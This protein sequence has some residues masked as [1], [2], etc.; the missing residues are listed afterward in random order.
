MLNLKLV[1]KMSIKREMHYN[2]L[3]FK[4]DDIQSNTFHYAKDIYLFLAQ[5]MNLKILTL[6]IHSFKTSKELEITREQ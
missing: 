3:N 4:V 6:I 2:S 1:K 5:L